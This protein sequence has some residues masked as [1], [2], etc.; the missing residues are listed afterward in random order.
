MKTILSVLCR[1]LQHRSHS[2]Q[3]HYLYMYQYLPKK[4][5]HQQ[6]KYMIPSSDQYCDISHN[7]KQQDFDFDDYSI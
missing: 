1:N 4:S 7:D 5:L 6:K 2:W 3:K